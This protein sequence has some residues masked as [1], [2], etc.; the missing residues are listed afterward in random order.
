MIEELQDDDETVAY[1]T[2]E[3]GRMFSEL[4]A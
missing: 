1:R 4:F 2:T 3:K